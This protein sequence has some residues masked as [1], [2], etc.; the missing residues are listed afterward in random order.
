[1][2]RFGRRKVEANA[3]VII[4]DAGREL[5]RQAILK[6][7]DEDAPQDF[8]AELQPWRDD[9][10]AAIRKH[11]CLDGHPDGTPPDGTPPPPTHK[12]RVRI[13]TEDDEE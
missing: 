3:L 2:E 10:K 1:L 4:P 6:Y 11:F 12:Y 8:E 9:L 13:E 7:L 5:C